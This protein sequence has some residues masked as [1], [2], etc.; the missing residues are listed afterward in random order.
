MGSS[1]EKN[2]YNYHLNNFKNYTTA[3]TGTENIY[4][5]GKTEATTIYVI[6][7]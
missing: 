7:I 5:S 3:V 1:T 4:V 2:P 6:L